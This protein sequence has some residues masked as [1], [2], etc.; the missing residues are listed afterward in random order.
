MG[1]KPFYWS[2]SIKQNQ[3]KTQN[4]NYTL[5]VRVIGRSEI[6]KMGCWFFSTQEVS[7]GTEQQNQRNNEK[8]NNKDLGRNQCNRDKNRE[9]EHNQVLGL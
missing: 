3:I 2:N 6:E 8:G 5:E 7:K 1:E 4:K 9:N